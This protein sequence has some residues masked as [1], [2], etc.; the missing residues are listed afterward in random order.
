[1][2]PFRC[3]IQPLSPDFVRSRGLYGNPG[4]FSWIRLLGLPVDSEANKRDFVFR[5]L[6]SWISLLGNGAGRDQDVT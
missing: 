6:F 1:M 4:L 2:E 5:S 3:E